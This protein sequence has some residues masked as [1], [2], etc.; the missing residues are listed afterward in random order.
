MPKLSSDP[1]EPSRPPSQPPSG[2]PLQ[3][4]Q[5]P[6]QT[7]ASLSWGLVDIEADRDEDP[8]MELGLPMPAVMDPVPVAPAR[9][10]AKVEAPDPH[11]L[12]LRPA[13]RSMEIPEAVI[14]PSVAPENKITD[15][16]PG[17]V[18]GGHGSPGGSIFPAGSSGLRA[19]LKPT[20]AR[21]QWP[22]FHAAMMECTNAARVVSLIWGGSLDLFSPQEWDSRWRRLSEMGEFSGD[23]S[24]KVSDAVRK[25][26][27]VVADLEREHGP[28]FRQDPEA[29][30]TQMT[31]VVLEKYDRQIGKLL[32]LREEYFRLLDMPE[33]PPANP[34]IQGRTWLLPWALSEPGEGGGLHFAADAA[35]IVAP[36]GM[37]LQAGTAVCLARAADLDDDDAACLSTRLSGDCLLLSEAQRQAWGTGMHLRGRVFWCVDLKARRK[38]KGARGGRKS[39]QG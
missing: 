35:L 33:E 18:P 9:P 27:V 20:K 24:W 10:K 28:W 15:K 16:V 37:V 4:P 30:R 5:E 21:P 1:F 17:P 38:R 6:I 12:I 36:E 19:E 26:G 34:T 31:G 2:P 3:G 32:A 25:M 39:R 22:G 14:E 8:P 23:G 11:G 13:I 7:A 29:F